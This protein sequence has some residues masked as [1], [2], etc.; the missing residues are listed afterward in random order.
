MSAYSRSYNPFDEDADEEDLRP[1]K[2]R[3]EGEDSR[4]PREPPDPQQCLRQEVLRRTEASLESTGRSLSSIYESEKVGIASSEELMRQRGVLQRTEQMVDKMEQ[5][6]KTSQR[7]INSIKSMFGGFVNYFKS[8]PA[9]TAPPP[10]GV[11]DPQPN[12]R[13]K[14]ALATSKEQE[15]NYQASH[16][17]LRR[18]QSSDAIGGT[19]SGASTDAYP[20]NQ[21]LRQY[22]Q[23]ID[24]NLD[25]M[26]KGLGRLKDIALGMQTEIDEQDELLGRLTTKVEKLDINIKSTDKKVRQL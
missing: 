10:N 2:W 1:A 23:K 5:D 17:N 22:H 14:E 13:L 7:H 4:R 24:S 3:E 26:S 19:H 18:L 16:P 20:K 8:K 15:E 6:L 9:D 21:H 12:T 25:E 11:I